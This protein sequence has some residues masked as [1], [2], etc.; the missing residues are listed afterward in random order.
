MREWFKKQVEQFISD[1]RDGIYDWF[2]PFIKE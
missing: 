1:M 2:G